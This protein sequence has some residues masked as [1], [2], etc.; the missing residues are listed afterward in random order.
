MS[1]TEWFYHRLIAV[2]L[3]SLDYHL[4]PNTSPSIRSKQRTDTSSASY[5]LNKHLRRKC[6]YKISFRALYTNT[7][8]FIYLDGGETSRGDRLRDLQ[9]VHQV[10]PPK[11]NV[12][13][14]H[15]LDR[16]L[17]WTRRALPRVGYHSGRMHY[18]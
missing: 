7:E 5:L 2:A 9:Q 10:Y 4:R 6:E 3:E 18:H 8:D 11:D 1:R 17:T 16:K 12:F 15:Q 14:G 13:G